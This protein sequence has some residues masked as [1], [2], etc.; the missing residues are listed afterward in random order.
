MR[1]GG[2]GH[3]LKIAL[4]FLHISHYEDFQPKVFFI[5]FI[6]VRTNSPKV[7]VFCG[8]SLNKGY[9][10]VFFIFFIF[11]H[12][13]S[14]KVVVFCGWSLN[15]SEYKLIPSNRSFVLTLN[16]ER[17]TLFSRVHY[18]CRWKTASI[19]VLVILSCFTSRHLSLSLTHTE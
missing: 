9:Y 18:P 4:R 3:F 12:R 5:F 16:G 10:G 7:V 1:D 6:F 2:F 14:H 11:V 13:N 19:V 15:I 17:K 8:W